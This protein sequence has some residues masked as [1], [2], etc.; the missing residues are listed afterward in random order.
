MIAKTAWP[1]PRS[2]YI[3]VPFCAH[4]CG[5]CDF[6]L[7]ARRDDLIEAYLEALAIELGRLERPREGDTLF[8][9]GGPPTPLAAPQLERLMAL[10]RRWFPS[11]RGAEICVE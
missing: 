4:R 8:F 7:V 10:A 9:G 2:A 11:A 6:T 5:Y 3:H 1:Q